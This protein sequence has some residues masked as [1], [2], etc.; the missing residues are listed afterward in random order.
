MKIQKLSS[1]IIR[2]PLTQPLS[3][4][5]KSFK[6]SESLLFLVKVDGV[7]GM[8]ECAPRPYVTGETIE[9]AILLFNSLLR[10]QL[11]DFS[12][13]TLEEVEEYLDSLIAD[14]NALK[15]GI[16]IAIWDAVGK[17]TQTPIYKRLFTKSTR[18][19]F[20]INGGVPFFAPRRKTMAWVKRFYS[21]GVRD[22]KVKVG[23]DMTEDLNRL[24][25]LR[26]EF[27]DIRLRI[28]ANA[29][30]GLKEAV[31]N[32]SKMEKYKIYYVEE[33]IKSRN[34]RDLRLLKKSIKIP[35]MVDESLV[36]ISDALALIELKACSWFNVRLS[37]NG[38][39]LKSKKLLELGKQ[40]GIEVQIGSH[41]GE[42]DILEAARRHFAFG[43]P[44]ID[45]FEGGTVMLFKEHVTQPPL[46]FSDDLLARIDSIDAPGL[47]VN[48]KEKY[49]RGFN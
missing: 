41:F 37:K 3:H 27:P 35:I 39:F 28:D 40:A 14:N 5:R 30:W 43:A 34:F 20:R 24:G 38:G 2:I 19:A 48:L 10:N 26:K 18:K 32:L 21:Q 11:V 49:L 17:L 1:Q 42:S 44:E 6:K 47:G 25:Y 13:K 33:P 8:G 9:S 45:S 4:S 7:N 15:A 23:K 31:K 36:S 29:A 46:S 16:G 22:F 12:F